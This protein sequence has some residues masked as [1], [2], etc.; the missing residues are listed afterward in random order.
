MVSYINIAL[1]KGRLGEK[2]YNLFKNIGFECKEIEENSRKLVFINEMM[3]VRYIL[4]KASDVPIYVERGAAD[5]GVVGKDTIMEEE[6]ELY[7]ILDLRFGKCRFAIASYKG[8]KLD[9]V[10][11]PIRVATK[12]PR[13]TKRYFMSSGQQIELIKLNGS[14]ELAPI[15]GLSDVIVDIVETGRTLRENGLEIIKEI[16]PVSARLVVNKVSFK[17]K[18][19]VIRQIANDISKVVREEKYDDKNFK[20]QK[21]G[22]QAVN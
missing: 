2:A 19:K 1:A 5:L 15:L 20:Q 13:I 11:G 22:L 21:S 9:V 18:N 14:V 17:T 3:K 8:Y 6:R 16:Y 12:Y 4:V 7:E 10:R